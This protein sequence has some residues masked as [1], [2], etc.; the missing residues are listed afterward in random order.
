M[1]SE[2]F[3]LE[4]MVCDMN[5]KFESELRLLNEDLVIEEFQN[6]IFV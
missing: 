5:G 4:L 2:V 3:E 1:V 6:G